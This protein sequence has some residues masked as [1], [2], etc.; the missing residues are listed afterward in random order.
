MSAQI[1]LEE[2][3]IE[4]TPVTLDF[5]KGGPDVAEMERLNPLGQ[6]P[7]LVHDQNQVLTQ[8]VAVLEYIAD[9]KP[10]AK[11]LPAVGTSERYDAM[12]WLAFVTSELH[13]TF[14]TLFSLQGISE[15]AEVQAEV[16]KW[17]TQSLDKYFAYVDK[18]LAGKQFMIGNNFTVVDSYL[19]VVTSWH[20]W[21]GVKIDHHKNL[22]TYLTN[23]YKRPSVQKCLKMGDLLD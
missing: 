17:A 21:T 18:H 15:K 11:L 4:Y 5:D 16:R 20:K 14:A 7:V 2:A 1:A 6:T 22:S 12:A 3:G 8:N 13:K 10:A 9:K 19:F 23:I